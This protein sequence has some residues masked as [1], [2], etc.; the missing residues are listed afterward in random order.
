M[1]KSYLQNQKN[2]AGRSKGFHDKAIINCQ[3]SAATFSGT[4]RKRRPFGDWKSSEITMHLK[5]TFESIIITEKFPKSQID[6]YV[7]VK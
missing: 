1:R 3:Y 2:R 7:E 5:Q 6:I 4:D